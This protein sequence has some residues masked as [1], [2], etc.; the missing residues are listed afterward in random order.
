MPPLGCDTGDE[1]SLRHLPDISDSSF[2]FQIPDSLSKA[3]LLLGDDDMSFLRD[4]NDSESTP[5]KAAPDPLTLS[6]ITPRPMHALSTVLQD[7]PKDTEAIPT[8]GIPLKPNL[9]RTPHGIAKTMLK[10]RMAHPTANP[11]LT[12]LS[13]TQAPLVVNTSSAASRLDTLRTE[14]QLLA[15]DQHELSE[16]SVHK[17]DVKALH[18]DEARFKGYKRTRPILKPKRTVIS[19][20]IS[21]TRNNNNYSLS[22]LPRNTTSAPN[23]QQ[24][25]SDQVTPPVASVAGELLQ[26]EQNP[27]ESMCSTAPGGVAERLVM[28]SQKFLS[29]FGS[30][31]PDCTAPAIDISPELAPHTDTIQTN[32]T[33]QVHERD[34]PLTLSQ[35]SPSKRVTS[36]PTESAEVTMSVPISPMRTSAKRPAPVT[37]ASTEPTAKKGKN[38]AVAADTQPAAPSAPVL[39][40]SARARV[41]KGGSSSGSTS[42]MRAR[43]T[44]AAKTSTLRKAP[45]SA[46]TSSTASVSAAQL[47]SSNQESVPARNNVSG[48]RCSSLVGSGSGSLHISHCDNLATSLN[49]PSEEQPQGSTSKKPGPTPLSMGTSTAQGTSFARRDM[50]VS[51]SSFP[52]RVNG[53]GLEAWTLRV[54]RLGDA[55]LPPVNP[56]KP[57]EF[58]FSVDA[59]I[60]SRKAES[61]KD[62]DKDKDVRP[63][64]SQSLSQKPRKQVPDFKTLHAQHEAEVAL[65]KENITPV[66]PLPLTLNTEERARER[67]RFDELV[68][69]KERELERAKEQRRKELEEAEEREI[70]ELRKRA[71]PKAHEV[72][73]W[74]K[75]APK[76]KKRE[77]DAS[78]N[79]GSGP[80]M[81]ALSLPFG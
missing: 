8:L 14:V 4:T 80:I 60:E 65:R 58:T 39:R 16:G 75:E 56:T 30:V 34:N 78:G 61:E 2:S 24:H 22:I 1:L 69:E 57:V 66:V 20:G 42:T 21:K 13:V 41:P 31:I 27:D 15:T 81:N 79:S 12:H 45:A 77:L 6:Q 36:I 10:T 37:G 35:L 11:K 29:S 55:V 74:Y 44:R 38:A 68:R 51:P 49:S 62:K 18:D 43:N 17:R 59:R 50:R 3:D 33:V 73:E 48:S 9:E 46:P 32:N 19:G 40:T 72:P 28:Y 63:F 7:Q 26:D 25:S 67:E 70:R 5:V 52:S 76:K 23:P 54:A 53:S 71:V 47:G 64:T